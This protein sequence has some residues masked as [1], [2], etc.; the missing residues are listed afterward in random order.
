MF[1]AERAKLIRPG[2]VKVETEEVELHDDR[3]LVE[4]ETLA[5]S[6]GTDLNLY[7]GV[8]HVRFGFNPGYPCLIASGDTG[9][10]RVIAVGR[11]MTGW[12][13]NDLVITGGL[14][15]RSALPDPDLKVPKLIRV[16]EDLD[17]ESVAFL[18]QIRVAL[19]AVRRARIV[20]GDTVVVIGLG[21]IGNFVVQLAKMAGAGKVIGIDLYPF[22]LKQALLAGAD[23]AIHAEDKHIDD[24][25]HRATGGHGADIIIDASGSSRT[26][27]NAFKWAAF[28][29]RIVILGWVIDPVKELFLGDYFHFKQL[30]IISSQVRYHYPGDV[31]HVRRWTEE[32][33]Y[34]YIF[35]LIRNHKLSIKP[36]IT[37]RFLIS[38]APE[39]FRML[40]E[41][42]D[43]VLGVLFV[44]EKSH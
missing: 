43:E 42:P 31:N 25:I 10:G 40:K 24:L 15:T 21:V 39:C 2:Q 22:R 3:V 17:K 30:E 44:K 29:G 35:D 41:R 9:V 38:E 19:N 11:N 20:L 7:R 4:M 34:Q 37:H 13:E 27:H 36:L 18:H 23:D 32:A 1:Q 16:P 33:N 26:I 5:L 8:S 12:K 6:G 14:S 28:M